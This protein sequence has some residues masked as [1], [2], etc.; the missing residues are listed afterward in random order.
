MGMAIDES[1]PFGLDDEQVRDC[2]ERAAV[3]PAGVTRYQAFA[4]HLEAEVANRLHET[5][6]GILPLLRAHENLRDHAGKLAGT[7]NHACR[8]IDTHTRFDTTP[9]RRALQDFAADFPAG[10]EE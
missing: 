4:Y 9:G 1:G 8:V 10:G 6:P 3:R 7:L 2:Y 5:V